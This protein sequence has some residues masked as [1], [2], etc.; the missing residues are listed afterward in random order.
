MISLLYSE[1]RS[2]GKHY[3]VLVALVLSLVLGVFLINKQT[4]D[5]DIEPYGVYFLLTTFAI[6]IMILP[7]VLALFISRASVRDFEQN[8]AE[9]VYT[10]AADR[11]PMLLARLLVFNLLCI[12]VFMCFGAG[13]VLGLIGNAEANLA[14]AAMTVTWGLLVFVVP[15]VILL[16]SVFFALGLWWKQSLPV[17]ILAAMLFFGYEFFMMLSG[18]PL[19]ASPVVP[20][21]SFVWWFAVLDIH[22]L[23]GFFAAVEG[24][25]PE[26]KNLQLPEL[27][28]VL[29]GNR[30]VVLGLGMVVGYMALNIPHVQTGTRAKWGVTNF[31]FR[32]FTSKNRKDLFVWLPTVDVLTVFHMA[33]KLLLNSR[34]FAVVCLMLL[35]VAGSEIYFGYAHLENLGT[36]ATASTMVT[37]NRYLSDILP[38]FSGLFLVLIAAEVCWRER[39]VSFAALVDS[40]PISNQA[41]FI[42]RL[43][44]IC[45]TPLLLITIT[46]V[47]SVAMQLAFSG[48]IDWRAYLAL[49]PYVGLPLLNIA[50]MCAV[51][52]HLAPGK[53]TGL[54]ITALITIWLESGLPLN[55]GLEHPL[56]TLGHHTLLVYSEVFGIAGPLDA[57]WLKTSLRFSLVILAAVLCM[58]RLRRGNELTAPAASRMS[59]STTA[60]GATAILFTFIAITDLLWSTHYQSDYLSSKEHQAWKADYEKQ[61]GHMQNLATL[62]NTAV[63]LTVELDPDSQSIVVEGEYRLINKTSEPIASLMFTTPRPFSF[64]NVFVQHA[65]Q[66][67]FDKR[68]QTQVYRFATPLM[69]G[70][71]TTLSF[72]AEYKEPDYEVDVADRFMSSEYVYLRMLRYLPWIGFVEPYRLQ[73]N[74]LRRRFGLSELTPNTLE[75]DLLASNGDMSDTLNW[76]ELDTT[77]ITRADHYAFAPG[78]LLWQRTENGKR[79][80]RYKTEG[81]VRNIGHVVSTNLPY[82][83][84]HAGEVSTQ[85]FYPHGREQWALKHL[86]AMEEMLNYGHLHFASLNLSDLRLVP[87]S[88]AFSAT[89]YAL[90]Q[91]IFIGER[92]GFHADLLDSEGFDHLYRRTAHEVAHQWWGHGLNGAATEGE[93]VLVETLAKYSEGVMLAQKYS[94]DYLKKLIEFEQSRYF[95]G[96]SRSV[97]DE[98][99]LYRADESYLIYSKGAAAMYAISQKLGVDPVNRALAKLLAVHRYPA[100]PATTLDLVQYLKEEVN[101]QHAHF[102]DNWFFDIKVH[103][104]AIAK[105][106]V[107]TSGS[108]YLVEVCLT[109]NKD[110]TEVLELVVRDSLAKTLTSIEVQIPGSVTEHC[111]DLILEHKPAVV[112]IDPR[113]LLLDS[114]RSN[115]RYLL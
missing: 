56:W 69:P 2:Q 84:G 31:S 113:L 21:T 100:I 33:I 17:Y 44:A 43:L 115:N 106:S 96:R 101:D 55:L 42:G 94:D 24:W 91:T 73:D 108:R 95:E 10:A 93:G 104:M 45:A 27:S 23:N 65:Q 70:A 79:L 71:E 52:H 97:I 40:S 19:M 88:Y 82:V 68:F 1:L 112:E 59:K 72:R 77:I 64:S 49:Y 9:L 80:F 6:Q 11:R 32:L 20:D 83:E 86:E 41:L 60:I 51:V 114:D 102:I 34:L 105:T 78:R 4:P 53:Y 48:D 111:V 62:S 8:M 26:Q 57:F 66:E 37:M 85:V 75:Q 47:L 63:T 90:P 81:A 35:V 30:L 5:T 28:G 36:R 46:I 29:I 109:V 38:T 58:S 14:T 15:S 7:G 74:G 98:V 13:L 89:G 110:T 61:Y 107:S 22:G 76:A 92:V 3:A 50:I 67:S 39:Q 87:A 12:A 99:P 54:A 16:T 103:D 25:T 18:S